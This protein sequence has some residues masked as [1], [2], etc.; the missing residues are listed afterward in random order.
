MNSLAAH[1]AV[2]GDVHLDV[3]CDN[4]YHLDILKCQTVSSVES[5]GH[6]TTHTRLPKWADFKWASYG[7]GVVEMLCGSH[8]R[9]CGVSIMIDLSAKASCLELGPCFGELASFCSMTNTKGVRVCTT[10]L[11]A[12][13]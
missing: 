11:T 12:A 13:D 5:G 1:C 3:Y 10:H 4:R 9:G 7:V 6:L 8:A 2:N